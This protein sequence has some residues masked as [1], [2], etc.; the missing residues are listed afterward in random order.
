M[1]LHKQPISVPFVGGVDRANDS[2]TVIPTKLNNLENLLFEKER[3]TAAGVSI[4]SNLKRRPGYA[5]AIDNVY[6]GTTALPSTLTGLA[7]LNELPILETPDGL[8]SLNLYDSLALKKAS[9]LNRFAPNINEIRHSDRNVKEY[10]FA[11]NGTYDCYFWVETIDDGTGLTSGQPWVMVKDSRTGQ[12]LLHTRP[13]IA[14]AAAT[15]QQPRIVVGDKGSSTFTFA[16]KFFCYVAGDNKAG[17]SVISAFTIDMANPTA[18]SAVN[19]VANN[20]TDTPFDVAV[21]NQWDTAGSGAFGDRYPFIVFHT[22]ANTITFAILNATD[23]YT[24]V[25][26]INRNI[27]V[28]ALHITALCVGLHTGLPGPAD[29]LFYAIWHANG[30]LQLSY[31][32]MAFGATANTVVST[33]AANIGRVTAYVPQNSAQV[34]CWFDVTAAAGTPGTTGTL[35]SVTFTIGGITVA[36]ATVVRSVMLATRAWVDPHDSKR[37]VGTYFMSG[38]QPTFYVLGLTGTYT[39]VEVVAR[40]SPAQ[41]GHV[42]DLWTRRQRVTTPGWRNTKSVSVLKT[43]NQILISSVGDLKT[44]AQTTI[45]G[46]IDITPTGVAELTLH[47]DTVNS[48][49]SGPGS[50]NTV[51]MSGSLLYAGACPHQFDG[52][53]LGE[54]GFHYF[55]EGITTGTQA[56]AISRPGTY[57]YV[58]VYEWIDAAGKSHLS[59]TSVPITVTIGANLDTLINAPTLR[60]TRKS[61]V[62]IAVFRTTNGGV[63]YYRLSRNTAGLPEL[64]S[65][66]TVNTVQIVDNCSD[67]ALVGGELLYTTGGVLDNDPYPACKHIGTHQDRLVFSGVER[68]HL[69]QYTEQRSE[70]FFPAHSSLYSLIVPEAGKRAVATASLD[71]NKLAII[72]EESVWVVFGLG[73]NRLGLENGFSEIQTVIQKLGCPWYGSSAVIADEFGVWFPTL[74]GMR[75][76]NKGLAL[77]ADESGTPMGLEVGADFLPRFAHRIPGKMQIWF[78]RPMGSYSAVWDFGARQWSRITKTGGAVLSAVYCT[79]TEDHLFLDSSAE[80]FSFLNAS[81]EDGDPVTTVLETAWIKLANLQGF[82]R[83][84]SMML[85]G[86]LYGT[87]L[88]SV[89]VKIGYDYDETTYSTPQTMT[90]VTEVTANG[91][92]QLQVKPAKQKCEAVRFHITI[93][94][95]APFALTSMELL[96]GGKPGIFKL[97]SAKRIA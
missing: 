63:I 26:S 25:N 51:E 39:D 75:H 96:L 29:S 13:L 86:K 53:T 31:T 43:Y 1:A 40:S 59:G 2:F 72:Q 91:K 79:L 70:F 3:N 66:P 35:Q 41:C 18:I 7:K 78:V 84:Y 24:I 8:Y 81:S 76:L 88:D 47:R 50:L 36:E 12:I 95:A 14:G 74:F 16:N 71:D 5:T 22:N 97:D 80:V 28:T 68:R 52:Q 73:P 67:A 89:S 94:N 32:D 58:L 61:N 57:S 9:K 27:G 44:A 92:F 65:D 19:T 30:N 42:Y 87:G 6:S 93:T 34:E 69:V 45:V 11:T 33:T 10:D 17:A 62:K 64:R 15:Y 48:G 23:G 77:S 54:L 21:S 60:L 55:P 4:Q 56:S 20:V 46:G 37:Y 90:P 49:A 82:Q 85:L 83:I 38:V